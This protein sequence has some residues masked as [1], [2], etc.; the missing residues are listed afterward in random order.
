MP[1]NRAQSDSPFYADAERRIWRLQLAIGALGTG[2]AWWLAGTG[3]AIAFSVGAVFSGLNFLWLTQ[4]VDALVAAATAA[5]AAAPDPLATRR[6]RRLLV[7]KFVGRYLLIGLAAYVILKHTAWSVGALL[8]GLFLFV[9]AVLAEIG[10]EIVAELK[11]KK[12][13]A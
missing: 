3:A 7:A 10:W 11:S 6:K 5:G 12:D 4:A 13:G 2:A 1:E 9:A 8:A